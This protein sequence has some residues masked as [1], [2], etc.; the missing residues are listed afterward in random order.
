MPLSEVILISMGLLSIAI[1][2][3]G[4][5]RHLSMPYTVLLVVIGI[6]LS[7]L[8]NLWPWLSPLKAFQLSPE[9]V[10]FVFLPALI[11]ESGL[12]LDARQLLKDLA[13]VLT[14]AVP[15]LLI[16]TSIVGFLIWLLLD[17]DLTIALLFGALISATDPV[18]V[19]AL[20]KELGAPLRLNVLV[21]GESLFNDATAIV[22]F[23]ILLTM[24]VQGESLS[25][26]SALSAIV[27]F[28][29][30]FIGGV[31]VGTLTGLLLSEILYRLQ[32]SVSAILTM[33]IV[34]AYASFIT[35]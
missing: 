22:V 4:L 17:M 13:P 26:G 10:F 3:A 14:L 19:V 8:E 33:S 12:S 7:E 30:V 11:F 18:A 1:L 16:S 27:E 5:L 34:M 25:V 31:V 32:S 21:E 6:S 15:A 35:V 23:G 24:V 20:F 9:L 2:A 29:R 28:I